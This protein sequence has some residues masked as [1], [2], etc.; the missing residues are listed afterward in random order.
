MRACENVRKQACACALIDDVC[1]GFAS[2]AIATVEAVLS[3]AVTH[4]YLDE[5][6]RVKRIDTREAMA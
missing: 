1:R 3:T 4:R 5:R 6:V 2:L